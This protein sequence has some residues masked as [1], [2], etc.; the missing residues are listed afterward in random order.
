MEYRIHEI[1][2][3]IKKNLVQLLIGCL[4][5]VAVIGLIVGASGNESHSETEMNKPGNLRRSEDSSTEPKSSSEPEK[6]SPEP[7]TSSPEPEKPVPTTVTKNF[8]IIKTHI[9][10]GTIQYYTQGLILKDQDTLIESAGLYGSSSIHYLNRADMTV[11]LEAPLDR[12]YFGEG[13]ELVNINGES[14]IYQLT[15]QE[16]KV[17]VWKAETL[18]QKEVLD[19]PKEIKSGWGITSRQEKGP[20]G[21]SRLYFYVSDGTQN[22]YVVDPE[23][24]SVVKTLTIKKSDESIVKNL[25][26]L[27]FIKGKLWANIYY[28]NEIV[29]INPVTG[30]V[31]K[32]LD[33]TELQKLAESKVQELKLR[34]QNDYVLNGIA[35]DSQNDRVI[36]TGKM[37]PIIWEIKVP[38]V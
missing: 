4:I 6:S 13:C 27:E 29:I 20:D 19:L 3:S 33:V 31:E 12:E 10:P 18:E 34:W 24:F 32:I 16:R 38:D 14:L 1:K 30:Y 26:E 15:W 21:I 36:I 2:K 11:G 25:N 22:I 7:E 17:F 9:R 8:E 35:Y 23:S 5:T 37:W 28:K